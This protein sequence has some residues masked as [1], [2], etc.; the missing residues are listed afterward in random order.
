ME[1]LKKSDRIISRAAMVKG[2]RASGCEVKEIQ[3]YCKFKNVYRGKIEV[4]LCL[5]E[6]IVAN[7]CVFYLLSDSLDNICTQILIDL[8]DIKIWL[9]EHGYKKDK[10]FYVEDCGMSEDLWNEWNNA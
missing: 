6:V 1:L 10:Q 9:N 2:L 8:D 3:E 7:G 4:K 5:H